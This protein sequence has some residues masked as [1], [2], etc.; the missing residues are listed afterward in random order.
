MMP[1]KRAPKV[2]STVQHDSTWQKC[3]QKVLH[4]RFVQ[5]QLNSKTNIIAATTS[6][7]VTELPLGIT[8]AAVMIAGNHHRLMYAVKS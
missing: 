4:A 2:F 8:A 1:S 5:P 3:E 6:A 7:A